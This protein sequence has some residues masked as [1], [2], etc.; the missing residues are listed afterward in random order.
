MFGRHR[1]Q[2]VTISFPLQKTK[3]VT[4]FSII[5]KFYIQFLTSILL[6]EVHKRNIRK[7]H[8]KYWKESTRMAIFDFF[9]RVSCFRHSWKT[10]LLS[11]NCLL[12]WQAAEKY[13]DGRYENWLKTWLWDLSNHP[14]CLQNRSF[15][16]LKNLRIQ[17]VVDWV[18][19]WRSPSGSFGDQSIWLL[20]SSLKCI[21]S[22]FSLW[23][24][25]GKE[26]FW[27]KGNFTLIFFIWNMW[28][29]NSIKKTHFFPLKKGSYEE[30]RESKFS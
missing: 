11:S 20:E 25:Q 7:E 9:S 23:V 30:E 1:S 3:P 29:E 18:T 21:I 4:K 5:Y 19:D 13:T 15:N 16:P 14:S 22:N 6:K 26:N 24:F 17:T 27:K 2:T 8:L 12:E 28:I 10:S